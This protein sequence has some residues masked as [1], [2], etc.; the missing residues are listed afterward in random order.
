MEQYRRYKNPEQVVDLVLEEKEE[1]FLCVLIPFI[2][3]N[4]SSF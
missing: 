4:V 1:E 3:M 2:L